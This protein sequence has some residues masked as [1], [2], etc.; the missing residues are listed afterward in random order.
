[1]LNTVHPEYLAKIMAHANEQRMTA[2]GEANQSES[3]RI[4]EYWQEQLKAMPYLSCKCPLCLTGYGPRRRSNY[5]FL[6]EIW[7]CPP[8]PQF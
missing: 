3:I 2:A 4:T 6:P 7:F 8:F 5:P 1:M